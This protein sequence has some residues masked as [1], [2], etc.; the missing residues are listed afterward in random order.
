MLD[1]IQAY[2]IG[3]LA[4]VS[5][6]NVPVGWKVA[7]SVPVG[8]VV[9][10]SQDNEQRDGPAKGIDSLDNCCLFAVA[11]LSQLRLATAIQ[12]CNH[13]ACAD[14]AHHK[15]CLVEVVDIVIHNAVLSLD[16][17]YKG[18]PLAKDL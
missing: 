9:L 14:D 5:S 8:R 12:G 2:S 6:C 1:P 11:R 16:V 3:S 10:R 4:I 15:P 18:K 7:L 13:H 17:P